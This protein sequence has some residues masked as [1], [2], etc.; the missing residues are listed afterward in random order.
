LELA[1]FWKL[2]DLKN[3]GILHLFCCHQFVDSLFVLLSLILAFF[4]LFFC[5][6]L[7]S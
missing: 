5:R 2:D 6:L 4:V 7:F 1:P 3:Y